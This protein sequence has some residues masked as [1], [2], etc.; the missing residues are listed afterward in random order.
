MRDR[1]KTADAIKFIHEQGF[2]RDVARREVA[3]IILLFTDGLSKT[4]HET[5]REAELAKRDGIYLFSIGIG[6]KHKN[7]CFLNVCCVMML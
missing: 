2:S 7:I 3:H 6:M 5:A 1:T 4:P